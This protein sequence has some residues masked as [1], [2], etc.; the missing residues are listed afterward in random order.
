ML[1]PMRTAAVGRDAGWQE[2]EVMLCLSDWLALKYCR[3]LEAWGSPA[4]NKVSVL[5][6]ERER[7]LPN[8]LKAENRSEREA[9][10]VLNLTETI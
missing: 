7:F 1:L 6:R 5:V 9:K 4:L 2:E 8:V 3:E 10:E